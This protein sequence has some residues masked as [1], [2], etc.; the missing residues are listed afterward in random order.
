M[1]IIPCFYEKQKTMLF[2][3]IDSIIK[4]HPNEK[5]IVVDSDSP[6]KSYF[7]NLPSKVEVLDIKNKNGLFCKYL[8]DN[9]KVIK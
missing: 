8:T 3:T 6:D 4:F 9:D 2:D 1:F 5:I 7:S